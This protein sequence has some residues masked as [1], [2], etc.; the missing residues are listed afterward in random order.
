MT[1]GSGSQV[2][3]SVT[4]M[5]T[6]L[7]MVFLLISVVFMEQV[8]QEKQ[9]VQKIA[10]T[11]KDYQDDLHNSLIQEFKQDLAKWDAG[12]LPDGTVRFYEPDV[13]FDEGSKKIKPRF[14]EI[15]SEFFPRYIRLLGND[16][17]RS[18]IEEVRIEG[19]TSSSWDES[20]SLEHRYLN[21]AL[22]SQARSF[23]ILDYCFRLP[24]IVQYQQWLTKVLR[25]NGLAFAAP[26]L[27]NGVEDA[28]R[29][30]RVEFKV[31][32]KADEKIR[33]IIHTVNE[34]ASKKSGDGSETH[35]VP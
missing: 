28:S 4:D 15:L 18:Q 10:L 27:T 5:M 11:Y 6:G 3:I 2:W 8:N 17:Y 1:H 23:V 30:R 24:Q 14:Q 19:H 35:K 34:S 12:I 16:K 13:L 21:N 9:A 29:S 7:M 25:A 31:R 26:V 20:K 32:T 22:L 33:E